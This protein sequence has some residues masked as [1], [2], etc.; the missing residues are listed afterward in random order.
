[1]ALPR[2]F[3]FCQ[4]WCESGSNACTWAAP[5]LVY[6]AISRSTS[7]GAGCFCSCDPAEQVDLERKAPLGLKVTP[8]DPQPESPHLRGIAVGLFLSS[9]A[10]KAPAVCSPLLLS[11]L[12]AFALIPSRY[13]RFG[14]QL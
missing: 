13:G 4:S 8:L 2:P 7:L 5:G 14:Y 3:W 1:M 10:G 12:S 11:A 9:G 6:V